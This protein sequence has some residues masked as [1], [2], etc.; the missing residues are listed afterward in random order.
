MDGTQEAV[1][2]M[3]TVIPR[4]LFE[5]FVIPDK[6][7]PGITEM[8]YAWMPDAVNGIERVRCR[9]AGWPGIRRSLRGGRAAC[10]PQNGNDEKDQA[11]LPGAVHI[12]LPFLP[13]PFHAIRGERRVVFPHPQPPQRSGNTAPGVPACGK[14]GKLPAYLKSSLSGLN[15]SLV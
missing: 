2:R 15:V 6:Q 1:H 14:P 7:F 11:S 4:G 12:F 13:I 8:V 9:C 5:P 3:E 10:D